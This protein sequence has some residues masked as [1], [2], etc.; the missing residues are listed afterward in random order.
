MKKTVRRGA[1]SQ[2]GPEIAPEGLLR[3]EL[4]AFALKA[5]LEVLGHMLEGGERSGP[6]APPPLSSGSLL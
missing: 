3:T 6:E 1:L 5:G 2:E 4:H